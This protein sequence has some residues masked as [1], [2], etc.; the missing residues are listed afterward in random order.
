MDWH[1]LVV[2]I[3]LYAAWHIQMGCQEG[4]A[5]RPDPV[6]RSKM[7]NQI[8]NNLDSFID[9]H[10]RMEDLRDKMPWMDAVTHHDVKQAVRLGAGREDIDKLLM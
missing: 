7:T 3:I 5:V 8:M 2:V 1:M 10:A 6:M 9:P 4:L